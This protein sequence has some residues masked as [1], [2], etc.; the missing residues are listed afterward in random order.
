MYNDGVIK[1]VKSKSKKTSFSGK[2]NESSLA[3]FDEVNEFLFE[4]TSK[5]PIKEKTTRYG[6]C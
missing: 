2:I 5:I 1:I 4:E 6:F 3:D